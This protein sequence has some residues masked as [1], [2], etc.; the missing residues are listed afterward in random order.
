MGKDAGGEGAAV[1]KRCLTCSASPPRHHFVIFPKKESSV[2]CQF[3]QGVTSADRCISFQRQMAPRCIHVQNPPQSSLVV[4]CGDA[5]KAS[6]VLLREQW[7]LLTN[8]STLSAFNSIHSLS[9][10]SGCR[11]AEL[12]QDIRATSGWDQLPRLLLLI[13]DSIDR[14][15]NRKHVH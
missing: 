7:T 10:L 14:R 2:P 6:S 8:K 1:Q 11:P 4:P 9:L 15:F 12:L 5:A 13:R 3:V